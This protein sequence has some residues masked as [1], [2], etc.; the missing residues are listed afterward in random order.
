MC[1]TDRAFWCTVERI[2]KR[3]TLPLYR[4]QQILEISPPS[5]YKN[6]EESPSRLDQ[7]NAVFDILVEALAHALAAGAKAALQAL[8][9]LFR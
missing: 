4:A 1:D 9:D 8:A 5:W 3:Q 6:S 2:P 7:E